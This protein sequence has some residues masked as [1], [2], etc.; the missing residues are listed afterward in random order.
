MFAVDDATADA[1]RRTFNERGEF[2]A[3]VELREHFRGIPDIAQ[4]RQHVRTIAGWQPIAVQPKAA[5][6]DSFTRAKVKQPPL[7]PKPV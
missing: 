4:A 7:T 6:Q 5:E 1:I 2:A 3:V